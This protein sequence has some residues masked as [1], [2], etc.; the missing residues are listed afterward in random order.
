M[1]P[2]GKRRCDASLRGLV[3]G[4][5]DRTV[6]RIRLV[7]LVAH[8][9]ACGAKEAKSSLPSKPFRRLYVLFRRGHEACTLYHVTGEHEQRA[10]V[11]Y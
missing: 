4:N 11:M 8:S 5:A 10:S 9:P 2:G 7:E 1:D 6:R 3:A